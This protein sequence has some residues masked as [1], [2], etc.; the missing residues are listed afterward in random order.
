VGRLEN[1]AYFVLIVRLCE[2]HNVH[3]AKRVLCLALFALL[4]DL[5]ML[6]RTRVIGQELAEILGK[7]KSLV[8]SALRKMEEMGIVV[9]PI[10][11]GPVGRPILIQFEYL[12]GLW[13]C[14]QDENPDNN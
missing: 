13:A 14:Q 3:G 4:M 7:N 10:V 1:T 12:D 9:R 5:R 8:A 11:V 2:K 6:G